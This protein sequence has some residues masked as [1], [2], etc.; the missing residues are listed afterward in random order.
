M[1]GTQGELRSRL[2]DGLCGDRPDGFAGLNQLAGRQVAAV[3]QR[4]DAALRLAGQYGTDFHGL[5]RC[6]GDL[7]C[8]FL[9]EHFTGVRDDL[10]VHRVGHIMHCNTAEDT[11]VQR[12]LDVFAFLQCACHH[13][14]DGAAVVNG[15]DGILG[16][17]DET[18]CQVPGISGFQRGVS[19]TFAR[20]VCGYEVLQYREAFTEICDDRVLD[21]FTGGS[22]EAFLR[23]GHETTHAGQLAHLLFGPAGAGINHH[24]ERVEA[25][26]RMRQGFKQ[27]VCNTARGP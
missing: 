9:I 13:A 26:T 22:G 25:L 12:L 5:D 21:Q 19:Q 16:H 11:L 15:D 17:V 6:L 27:T 18:A 2:A 8:L 20:T 1:E 23:L 3:A 7:V 10:V 14:A 4:A 24:I